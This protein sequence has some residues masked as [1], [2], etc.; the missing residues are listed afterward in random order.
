MTATHPCADE[1]VELYFYGELS[2]GARRDMDEHLR[3][4]ARCR[5]SLDDLRAIEAALASRSDDP[6]PE[7]GWTAFMSRL[8]ARLD[9]V[10]RAGRWGE[11]RFAGLFRLAAAL[12]LVASGALAGWTLS[13]FAP[14]PPPADMPAAVRADRVLTDASGAG[15]ER[16]RV[17][18]AGLAQKDDGAEWS[19]EKRMAAT[20]LPEVRLLR[21]AASDR[22]RADLSDILLD[23]ETLLLQASYAP[24]NDSETLARLRAMIDRRD[25][26]M[27]L[28]LAGGL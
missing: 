1:R 18:L 12:A 21:Q 7:D 28:S 19:L 14:A 16:A 15:L 20:L 10:G 27:R 3:E 9:T 13:R 23:V 11:S 6:A 26:L 4:C 25:V 22:G 8:D 5:G 17:V 2:A 24:E